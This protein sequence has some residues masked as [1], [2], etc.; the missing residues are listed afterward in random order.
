MLFN[1]LV[2]GYVDEAVASKVLR[3][4]GHEPGIA[5]GKKGWTYIEK[6]IVAFDRTTGVQGLLTLV[7]FMDTRKDCPASVVR[8]WL[9][10]RSLMHVFRIVVREIES[11]LLADRDALARFLSVAV[12]KIPINTDAVID[13][14]QLLI[15]LARTSRSRAIRE[16]LVPPP[17]Y[18]AVEG[19]LYSTEIVRF[20]SD[21]WD[22][23][24]ARS[25]S[26]SLNRC[27]ARLVEIHER[28]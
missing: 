16:A 6:K 24:S 8:D 18:S 28:I 5:Y 10:Q 12:N 1:L 13:P 7:D 25:Q 4:C 27:M 9:P 15:N 23:E 26:D 17:G 22:P 11:W 21:S 2:E 20:V 19:P 14:K 3:A